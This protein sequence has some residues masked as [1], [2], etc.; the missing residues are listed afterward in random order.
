MKKNLQKLMQQIGL[1]HLALVLLMI[2]LGACRNETPGSSQV[3]EQEEI[4]IPLPSFERWEAEKPKHENSYTY[5]VSFSS[6]SGFGNITTI[7]VTNGTVTQ[8][9]FQAYETN[10]STGQKT[11]TRTWSERQDLNSHNEGA[12]ATTLDVVYGKC[13][14]QWLKVSPDSN[15][16][17]FEG[18][19]NGIISLC[20]Y[21]PNLCA[22]DCFQ[23][24]SISDFKWLR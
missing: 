2:A 14:N 18:K 17:Y 23:G 20:G 24:V 7:T 9:D 6:A 4:N 22:D 8:R 15:T 5:T 21:V 10:G 11:I 16:T 19:H 3:E 1:T 12:E 13:L